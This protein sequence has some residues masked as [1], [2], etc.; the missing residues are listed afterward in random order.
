[1]SAL[2][3]LSSHAA[4]APAAARGRFLIAGSGSIGRRHLENL[5]RLGHDAFLYRTGRRD[6]AAPAVEAPAEYDVERALDAGP[7]AVLVCNPSA[8]HLELAL[9]A[10][11]RGL[12][13]L[14]EKPLGHTLEGTAE[15]VAEVER[16][17]LVALVGFQYRFHP[18]LRRVKAWL[19]DGA[20]GE[21]VSVQVH[22]GEDL[23]GWHPGEDWRASYAARADLGGGAVR[24]LCH[25]FDY[26][27]YL[28]GEVESV[29]A[30]VSRRALGLDV[31]DTAHVSL[32]FA[33][34]V[35]ASVVL[36]YLQRPR[37]HDLELVGTRGRIR[38]SDADGSAYLHDTRRERVAPFLPAAGFS[39]NDMFL[40]ELAHFLACL[41]GVAA[42]QCTLVD[43]VRAL[44]IAVLALRSAREG[45]QLRLSEAS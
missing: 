22:W 45:R 13:L 8:L 33:S 19:D 12:H 5:R 29:S 36:D 1:M 44:E 18:G 31:E 21:L 30:L 6:P 9:A 15:L 38:W 16:R 41:D 34:G 14:V 35:L 32:R 25:P 42:P 4:A 24:T 10:A 23:A 40:D 39:R 7:R 17:R 43:G 3:G 28:L 2:P 26:L 27:R 11:R 20:L 37:T